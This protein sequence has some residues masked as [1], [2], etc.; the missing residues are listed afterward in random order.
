MRRMRDESGGRGRRVP[1]SRKISGGRP[2][3]N[4]DIPVSFFLTH[5]NFAL[6]TIFKTS[7]TPCL[8]MNE[9]ARKISVSLF[10]VWLQCQGSAVSETTKLETHVRMCSHPTSDSCKSRNYWVSSH[11]SIF[12][13]IGHSDPEIRRCGCTCARTE[14]PHTTPDL[15][16][17]RT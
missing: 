1:R 11:T 2:H 4:D 12:S 13:T 10:L 6:S 17:A 5:D 7:K 14:M 9:R 3:R 15:W 8:A 16:K